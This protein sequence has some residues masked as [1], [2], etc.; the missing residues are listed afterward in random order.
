MR[1]GNASARGARP[2]GA[3]LLLEIGSEELPSQFVTPAL[4]ELAAQ[5]TGLLAAARLRHGTMTTLGTHRDGSHGA[6][7][8]GRVRP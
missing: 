3:E 7:A 4:G 8:R 2:P 6:V 5:A 1:Q